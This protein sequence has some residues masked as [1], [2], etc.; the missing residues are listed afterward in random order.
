MDA[1]ISIK[2]DLAPLADQNHQVLLL[3]DGCKVGDGH[4]G[5]LALKYPGFAI[6]PASKA[7]ELDVEGSNPHFSPG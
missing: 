5:D 1:L 2:H 3:A 7:D 4:F 6:L